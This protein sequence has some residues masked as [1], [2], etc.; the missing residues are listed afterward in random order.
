MALA[1]IWGHS[2]VTM[3]MF[4]HESGRIVE[5][6]TLQILSIFGIGIDEVSTCLERKLAR[7][8]EFFVFRVLFFSDLVFN[9]CDQKHILHR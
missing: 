7:T 5:P 8:S 4:V 2:L 9:S 6:I 1:H 3:A